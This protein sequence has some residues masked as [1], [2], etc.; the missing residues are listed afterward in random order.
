MPKHKKR[1][2]SFKKVKKRALRLF[3]TVGVLSSIALVVWGV[4]TIQHIFEP[5][6]GSAANYSTVQTNPIDNDIYTFSTVYTEQSEITAVVITN[7][8]KRERTVKELLL[9]NDLLLQMPAG[10]QEYPLRSVLKIS[11]LSNIDTKLIL[12][13]SLHHFIGAITDKL[14]ITSVEIDSWLNQGLIIP[15]ILASPNWVSDHFQTDLTR[16]ELI[17]IIN[18]YTLHKKY[19]FQRTDLAQQKLGTK[20]TQKDGSQSIKVLPSEI[21]PISKNIF[22]DLQLK[23]EGATVSVVNT[24]N[25]EGLA[26]YLSRILENTGLR[27]TEVTSF[28]PTYARSTI[29][30][31]ENFGLQNHTINKILSAVP[32]AEIKTSASA[33]QTDLVIYLGQDYASLVKG[34]KE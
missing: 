11:E 21:D 4:L 14:I 10:L 18:D 29:E 28:K 22:E 5:I 26:R 32:N 31:D 7:I 8:D 9:P 30:V 27:V 17:R 1:A 23:Y 19:H 25:S 6:S 2:T 15:K 16:F 34:L 24:T 12:K 20:L 33:S 3:V 13:E